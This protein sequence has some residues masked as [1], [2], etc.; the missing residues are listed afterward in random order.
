MAS[1]TDEDWDGIF[2][3]ILKS[4]KECKSTSDAI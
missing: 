3:N 2:K 1:E 4:V